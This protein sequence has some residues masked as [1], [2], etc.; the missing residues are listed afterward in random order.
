M[1]YLPVTYTPLVNRHGVIPPRPLGLHYRSVAVLPQNLRLEI[2]DAQRS[3]V[4]GGFADH[5]A[6][7]GLHAEVSSHRNRRPTKFREQFNCRLRRSPIYVGYRDPCPMRHEQSRRRA[8]LAHTCT[9]RNATLPCKRGPNTV[10]VPSALLG[11]P[12]QFPVGHRA[13]EGIR[14]VPRGQRILIN[15]VVT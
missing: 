11:V 10:R 1:P 9:V 7:V 15:N 4:I 2:Q 6:H 3:E 12:R 5:L 14:L 8:L 13:V